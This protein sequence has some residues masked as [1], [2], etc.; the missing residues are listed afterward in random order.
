[1]LAASQ[2]SVDLED[3]AISILRLDGRSNL[4]EHPN[5]KSGRSWI[6]LIKTKN[7]LT[8]SDLTAAELKKSGSDRE[9]IH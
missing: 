6:I 7:F 3:S 9:E 8:A 1:M 2:P 4:R 5:L